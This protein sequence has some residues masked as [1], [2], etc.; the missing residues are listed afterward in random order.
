MPQNFSPRGACNAPCLLRNHNAKQPQ[1]TS[2]RLLSSDQTPITFSN[3]NPGKNRSNLTKLVVSSSTPVS[4]FVATFQRRF[5]VPN[6]CVHC[7]L[8]VKWYFL[9]QFVFAFVFYVHVAWHP[10]LM[11]AMMHLY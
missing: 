8:S 9:H 5:T 3:D 11:I 10:L 6:F 2:A 4:S 7:I 1:F